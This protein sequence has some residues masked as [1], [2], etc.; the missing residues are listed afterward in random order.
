MSAKPECIHIDELLQRFDGILFDAYGVLV[1]SDSSLPGAR[2]LIDYLNDQRFPYLVV[3]NGSSQSPAD[4][5][6]RYQQRGLAIDPAAVL[7]SGSL[8]GSWVEDNGLAG[9]RAFVLGPDSAIALVEDSGLSVTTVLD[10]RVEVVIVAN[11][12]GFE[13]LPTCNDLVSFLC[14]AC[15]RGDV[16]RLVLP[17]PDLVY[18]AGKGALGFTSGSIVL[19]L[20]SVLQL[21]FGARAPRFERLG[22][23]HE[24]IFREARR[25]LRSCKRL[26]MIGDQLATDI[27]G[28][29]DSSL[30]SVL[31]GTGVTNLGANLSY[32]EVC[33]DYLMK[34]LSFRSTPT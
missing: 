4:T 30:S 21:R 33:P 2:S 32:D 12:D 6:Q 1:D 7:T 13:F 20:E 19:M 34:D 10:D 28:A 18:P 8:V 26:V 15:D 5:A 25:R 11:Q 17:N 3:T 24:P 27:L 22:K 9:A 14:R 31:I 23:P 16:P 29:R